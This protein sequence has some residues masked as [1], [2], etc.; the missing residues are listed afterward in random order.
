MIVFNQAWII[1]EILVIRPPHI[2][3]IPAT[4]IIIKRGVNVEVILEVR[5]VGCVLDL[6]V[7]LLEEGIAVF[8]EVVVKLHFV[9]V[10]L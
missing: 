2:G 4:T 9:V 7:G 8:E 10:Y 6:G 5:L 3:R 1:L